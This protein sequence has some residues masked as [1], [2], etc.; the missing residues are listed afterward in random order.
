MKRH[1]VYGLATLVL[2]VGSAMTFK[3]I[4]GECPLACFLHHVHGLHGEA[5]AGN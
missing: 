1:L 2:V 3:A 4:T 5:P